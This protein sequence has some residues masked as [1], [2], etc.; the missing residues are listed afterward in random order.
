MSILE[1]ATKSYTLACPACGS[2]ALYVTHTGRRFLVWC[3]GCPQ[4]AAEQLSLLV[5][6]CGLA[7]NMRG[8]FLADP[9][10]YLGTPL[11]AG[12]SDREPAPLPSERQVR[13][14]HAALEDSRAARLYVTRKRGL[15]WK[16]IDRYQL[17]YD[18]A[19]ITFPVRD[20][21]GNLA[22]LK[23]RMLDPDAKRAKLALAG[24]PWGVYPAPPPRRWREFVLCEGEFDCLL[25]RQRRIRAVTNTHGAAVNADVLAD[26][27]PNG[28]HIT[29][30]Y[31]VGAENRAEATRAKL[32]AAGAE[33]RV[34]HLPLPFKGDDVTDW[35]VREGRSGYA[36]RALLRWPAEVAA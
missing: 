31:D 1:H 14:W 15:T 8:M 13:E 5:E 29:V 27:A 11:A 23:R 25:L 10:R 16:T 4:D 9:L 20:A 2:D 24:R 34:V 6:A 30:L 18:G 26:L 12:R 28:R 32:A 21:A 3:H 19:A 36:M 7:P 22:N 33:V 35:F 17:G